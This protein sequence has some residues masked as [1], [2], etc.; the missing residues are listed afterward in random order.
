VGQQLGFGAV[1]SRLGAISIAV[2][3][4]ATSR[5]PSALT[6]ANPTTATYSTACR[7]IG[8]EYRLVGNLPKVLLSH[9]RWLAGYHNRRVVMALHNDQRATPGCQL[10]S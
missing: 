10:I 3:L 9:P 4:L 8:W 2:R 1:A 6:R 7:R 5:K